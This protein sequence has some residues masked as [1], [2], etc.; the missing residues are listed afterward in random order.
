MSGAQF[1]RFSVVGYHNK[2]HACQLGNLAIMIWY[3]MI[4]K[5]LLLCIILNNICGHL[6]YLTYDTMQYGGS[7]MILV[8]DITT[9]SN[10]QNSG[11]G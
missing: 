2:Q 5:H 11:I 8:Y 1:V 9:T 4:I 7:I 3:H 10:L 6:K